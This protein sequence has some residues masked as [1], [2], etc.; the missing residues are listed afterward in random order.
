MGG[1]CLGNGIT[2]GCEGF[3]RAIS[4]PINVGETYRGGIG[5]LPLE[6]LDPRVRGKTRMAEGAYAGNCGDKGFA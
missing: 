6:M 5:R 1:E 4:C 3:N 2:G